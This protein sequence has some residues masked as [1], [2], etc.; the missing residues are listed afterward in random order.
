MA[1][2]ERQTNRHQ[3]IKTLC[4]NR[5][6]VFCYLCGCILTVAQYSQEKEHRVSDCAMF[7]FLHF[8]FFRACVL[9]EYGLQSVTQQNQPF[10]GDTDLS[11]SG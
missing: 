8:H 9:F 7:F 11:I 3:D 2:T 6:I 1:Q 10:D 5:P 4:L